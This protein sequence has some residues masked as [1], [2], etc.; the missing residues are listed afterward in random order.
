LARRLSVASVALFASAP[1]PVIAPAT[2]SPVAPVA[3]PPAS[4]AHIPA[5]TVPA[6]PPARRCRHNPA[7][8]HVPDVPSGR[9]RYSPS[10]PPCAATC[11]SGPGVARSPFARSRGRAP[12]AAALPPLP[13]ALAP[14]SSDP[15]THATTPAA[16]APGGWHRA[17]PSSPAAR[18]APP[19]SEE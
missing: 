12:G 1:L 18:G 10:S 9:L 17:D 8:L 15:A 16:P 19:R 5:P 14:P 7:L 11:A 13:A 2:S 4:A 6:A 3:P